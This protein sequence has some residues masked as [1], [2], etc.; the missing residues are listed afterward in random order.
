MNQHICCVHDLLLPLQNDKN[1]A[2]HHCT[3]RII[4]DLYIWQSKQWLF[5]CSRIGG[6]TGASAMCRVFLISV[7]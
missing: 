7:P 2:L 3:P 4:I 6:H 1:R 5:V